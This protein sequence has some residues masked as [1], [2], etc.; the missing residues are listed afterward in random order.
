MLLMPPSFSNP[1]W[2]VFIVATGRQYSSAPVD[3]IITKIIDRPTVRNRMSLALFVFDLACDC[4]CPDN[5][6]PVPQ[7]WR[8]LTNRILS[9][10]SPRVKVEPTERDQF[11]G[12]CGKNAVGLN[13]GRDYGD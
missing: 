6:A 8:R 4:V 7:R 9:A 1:I 2:T 3:K 13:R 10:V 11:G 5:I 12:H